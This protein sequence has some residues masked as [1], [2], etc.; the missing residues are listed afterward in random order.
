MYSCLT[1][2]VKMTVDNVMV[3]PYFYQEA[4]SLFM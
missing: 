2:Q 3:L 1:N 4:Y